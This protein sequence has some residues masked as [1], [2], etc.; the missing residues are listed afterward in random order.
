MDSLSN[1]PLL[2]SITPYPESSNYELNLIPPYM[3]HQGIAIEPKDDIAVFSKCRV[4]PLPIF[5][6]QTLRSETIIFFLYQNVF[7]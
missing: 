1:K 4:Q 2:P 6:P 3:Y 7:F 5:N